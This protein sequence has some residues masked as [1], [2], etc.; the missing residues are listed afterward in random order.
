MNTN[1]SFTEYDSKRLENHYLQITTPPSSTSTTSPPYSER[2]SL[3]INAIA[4]I[5]SGICQ[6]HFKITKLNYPSS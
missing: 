2:V 4:L 5:V 3:L 6:V 1:P